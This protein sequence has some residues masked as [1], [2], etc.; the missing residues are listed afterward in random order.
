MV[1]IIQR[2][3]IPTMLVLTAAVLSG[4]GILFGGGEEAPTPTAMVAR[5]GAHLHG[6]ARH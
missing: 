2:I 1:R 5:V 3:G 6:D 4:C